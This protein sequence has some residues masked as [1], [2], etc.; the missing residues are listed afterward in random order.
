MYVLIINLKQLKVKEVNMD[1]LIKAV[2]FAVLFVLIRPV[3]SRVFDWIG[4]KRGKS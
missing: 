2:A 4:G 3:V 1:L